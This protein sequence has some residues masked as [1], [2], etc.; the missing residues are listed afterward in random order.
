MD[1][2]LI[3][4]EFGLKGVPN[5]IFLGF[6]REVHFELI[7]DSEHSRPIF[8]LSTGFDRIR[9]YFDFKILAISRGSLGLGKPF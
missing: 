6:Y 1:R 4:S 2:I 9:W 3:G 8:I 5:T 7:C